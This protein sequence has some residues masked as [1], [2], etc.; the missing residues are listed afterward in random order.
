MREALGDVER[1]ACLGAELDAEPAQARRRAGTEIDDHVPDRAG[2]APHELGFAVGRGLVVHAAQGVCVRVARDV[3][4]RKPGRG[5][6]CGRELALAVAAGEESALVEPCA[7]SRSRTRPR[8]ASSGI[9]RR[10]AV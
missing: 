10:R 3:A 4:L 1:V 2:G 7:R 5:S 8:G 6:P 9:A